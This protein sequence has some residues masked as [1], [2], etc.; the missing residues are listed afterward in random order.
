MHPVIW[1]VLF[2]VAALGLAIRGIAL[3]ATQ[4]AKPGR[5]ISVTGVIAMVSVSFFGFVAPFVCNA[6]EALYTEFGVKL[7]PITNLTLAFFALAFRH[8][9]LWFPTAL[10]LSLCALMIPE[11]FIRRSNTE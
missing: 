11:I 9:F 6:I 5:F 4:R 7:P 8:Q 10:V 1:V 3:L 2:C